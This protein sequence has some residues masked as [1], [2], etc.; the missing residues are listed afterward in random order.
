M[1]HRNGVKL[2]PC[3]LDVGDYVLTPSIVV[4]RKALTDLIG[5]LNN[6]RLFTQ[7]EQMK[8]HY[9]KPMLLIEFE[10]G[11]PFALRALR[12]KTGQI[13]ELMKTNLKKK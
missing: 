13:K 11:K 8:R 6:G 7:L 12:I 1:I 4:E 9:N 3:M 2:E 5:S 10:A